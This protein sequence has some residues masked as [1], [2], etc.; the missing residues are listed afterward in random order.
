VELDVLAGMWTEDL[1]DVSDEELHQA[2]RNV[3]REST[4]FPTIAAVRKA[5][6]TIRQQPAT[7]SGKDEL[8]QR[9]QRMSDEEAE[10]N[11]RRARELCERLA[12]GMKV[13]Q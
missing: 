8:P 12:A 6:E 7:H 11:K 2:V 5:A 10:E 4:F 1:A 3:R 13:Q 9:P